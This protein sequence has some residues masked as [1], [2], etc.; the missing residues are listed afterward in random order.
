MDKKYYAVTIHDKATGKTKLI[1]VPQV[2]AEIIE[3]FQDNSYIDDI[4]TIS[5]TELSYYFDEEFD[6]ENY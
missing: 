5:I 3:F 1:K 6:L 2:G 4:Y